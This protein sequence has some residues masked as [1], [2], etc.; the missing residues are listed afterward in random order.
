VRVFFQPYLAEA[1]KTF[2]TNIKCQAC[3]AAV[4]P[5]LDQAVGEGQWSV[6]LKSPDRVLTVQAAPEKAAA[7]VQAAGYQAQP[8]G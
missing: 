1:M 8:L 7:A 5:H 3:V 4:K 6:D 2:K